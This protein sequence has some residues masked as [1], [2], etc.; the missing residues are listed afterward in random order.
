VV[1]TPIQGS[2]KLQAQVTSNKQQS[3]A[4]VKRRRRRRRRSQEEVIYNPEQ[5]QWQVFFGYF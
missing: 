5:K 1:V 4:P 2:C 3:T